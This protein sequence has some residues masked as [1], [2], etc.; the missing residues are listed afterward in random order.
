MRLNPLCIDVA[1]RG[2]PAR[3]TELPTSCHSC[4][5]FAADLPSPEVCPPFSARVGA[6]VRTSSLFFC[7]MNESAVICSE[8]R[9]APRARIASDFND[10]Q[11]LCADAVM[12]AHSQCSS[13]KP[14]ALG[15]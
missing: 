2:Q 14:R 15:T 9:E 4:G 7:L 6:A 8:T 12:K 11:L 1:L 3:P 13:H 10:F 5:Y